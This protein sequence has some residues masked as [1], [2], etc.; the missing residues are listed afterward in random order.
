MQLDLSN[1]LAGF[2]QEPREG[3]KWKDPC[4]DLCCSSY[5]R[6]SSLYSSFYHHWSLRQKIIWLGS[7]HQMW[8]L[9][10]WRLS[11]VNVKIEET[12]QRELMFLNNRRYSR[13]KFCN[14]NGSHPVS[15]S[16][17]TNSSDQLRTSSRIKWSHI[18]ADA[19]GSLVPFLL[20]EV[21]IYDHPCCML[22]C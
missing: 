19:W 12:V 13:A 6:G 17:P 16:F 21:C 15:S 11:L 3:V 8:Q 22:C 9:K 4:H 2:Q 1:N 18:S 10:Q 7:Y 5:K 20:Q 14:K